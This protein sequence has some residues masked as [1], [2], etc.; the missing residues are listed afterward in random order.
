[1]GLFLHKLFH[2]IIDWALRPPNVGVGLL[3]AA[4]TL[5][6]LVFSFDFLAQVD[7]R[8]T[9]RSVSFRFASGEGL[10]SWATLLAYAIACVLTIAG[11]VVLGIQAWTDIRRERRQIV[12]V[13]E[14]R[15]LHS[16]PDTPAKGVDLG[17]Q[18]GER[19]WLQVDFRPAQEG[20]LVN[21]ELMLEQ[22]KSIRPTIRSLAAGRDK[23]DVFLA[24][25]GLAAVPALFLTGMLLDD[26]SH[27]TL[28]DWDRDAKTW[29]SISGLDDGKRFLPLKQETP[30]SE[31]YEAVLAVSVSYPINTTA[32]TLTFGTKL[33][34]Y[35]LAVEEVFADRHWSLDKQQALVREFR[36]TLQFL[37][38]KGIERIHLVLAA[39]AS[40]SIRMGMAYDKRLMPD[41]LVYQFEKSASPPYPWAVVMPTHGKEAAISLL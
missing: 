7:V 37:M 30:G 20:D 1:M 24:V 11:L 4:M 21:P 8:D 12:I 34:V 31:L 9:H 6:A 22:V 27:V 10:P 18:R 19:H 26:E 38:G 35:R 32:I 5:F 39:P 17:P 40:L 41:L 23:S 3:R 14:L 33:P 25:G 15:G 16:S 13:V 2:R 36:D 29:R 28:F